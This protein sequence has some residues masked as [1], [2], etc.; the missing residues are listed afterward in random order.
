[1]LR[2][3]YHVLKLSTSLYAIPKMERIFRPRDLVGKRDDSP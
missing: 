1:M 2:L 3:G